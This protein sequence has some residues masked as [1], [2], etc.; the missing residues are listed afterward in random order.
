MPTHRLVG[1]AR[2]RGRIK[3]DVEGRI[4]LRLELFVGAVKAGRLP[5][6]WD[7]EERPSL[8]GNLRYMNAWLWGQIA[9]T[10]K[11]LPPNIAV[12]AEHIGQGPAK[13][14]V[15]AERPGTPGRADR[16]IEGIMGEFDFAHHDDS[17]RGKGTLAK[18]RSEAASGL[19]R[20]QRVPLRL[21]GVLA[22]ARFERNHGAWLDR[23][24]TANRHASRRRGPVRGEHADRTAAPREPYRVGSLGFKTWR[25]VVRP[26]LDLLACP[27]D[28]LLTPLYSQA[29]ECIDERQP[30][31]DKWTD[32]AELIKLFRNPR[33][34][35]VFT[36]A[37]VE[38][39][40]L[41]GEHVRLAVQRACRQ[42]RK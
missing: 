37:E 1:A 29:L 24:N 42:K 5:A 18:G 34:Y 30:V 12:I 7:D 17:L 13:A 21:F 10:L 15:E 8:I 14:W 32:M 6:R 9:A 19:R 25:G 39:P 35:V 40:E 28:R 27:L 38:F 26:R 22:R 36:Q 2:E 3:M 33:P 16:V 23:L 41:T 4:D 20:G 31:R 11:L